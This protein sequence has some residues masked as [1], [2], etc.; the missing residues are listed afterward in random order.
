M[1]KRY[2]WTFII[3]LIIVFIITNIFIQNK[4]KINLVEYLQYRQGLTK[5]E[6]NYLANNKKLIYSSDRNSPPM[7]FMDPE[8]KQYKGGVI[9]YMNSL[10]VEL[11]V[12]IDF[13]PLVWEEAL[14]QLE[15]GKTDICDMFY[16]EK[17]AEDYLFSDPVYLLRSVILVKN[18]NQSINTINDLDGKK[19]AMQKSDYAVDYVKDKIGQKANYFLVNNIEEAIELLVNNKVEAVV[20]DEPVVTYFSSTKNLNNELKIINPPLYEKYIRFAVPKGEEK[21]VSILNKSIFSLRRK[22]ILE[23]IQ[24]KWFGLSGSI[25]EKGINRYLSIVFI[26]ISILIVII[27]L[28]F[29]WNYI[30]NK[31]IEKRTKELKDSKNKLQ[32][33]FDGVEDLMILLDKNY[34]IDNVN[35]SFCDFSGVKKEDLIARKCSNNLLYDNEK[36]LLKYCKDKKIEQSFLDGK[37]RVKEINFKNKVFKMG[38]LPIQ[39]DTKNSEDKNRKILVV[40]RDITKELLNEKKLFHANKMAAIGQLAAGMAHEIRNPLGLIRTYNYLLKNKIDN[41]SEDM[42]KHFKEIEKSIEKISRII[43]DLLNTSHSGNDQKEW[44]NINNY[45]KRIFSLHKNLMDNIN[46]I[47]NGDR[48]IEI[49]INKDRLEYILFNLISNA[50]DAIQKDGKINIDYGIKNDK[51]NIIVKDNGKG[52]KDK[53]LENIFN[54]FFTTKSP[55]EGTGLGLYIV[56]TE[57]EK[58]NGE[59]NVESEKGKGTIFEI[60]LEVEVRRKANGISKN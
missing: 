32:T 29:V 28:F 43:D 23:G 15:E 35:K 22:G 11:G 37:R 14:K 33:I 50:V 38:I 27:T 56:Y 10:S 3:L 47:I 52:I 53:N 8:D 59:I 34:I 46:W 12:E 16:S 4:Y 9:D 13:K 54:P 42:E 17:R 5:S 24:Q 49:Y 44:I 48:D 39:I 31:R 20:G 26:S 25:M 18:S 55:G 58:M 51:F 45:V 6:K 40:F 36:L 21:L 19:V 60:T 57:V 2:I 41:K 30:L 1:K 7:R